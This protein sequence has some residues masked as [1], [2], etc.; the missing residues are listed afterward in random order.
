MTTPAIR[1]ITLGI[2]S[3]HD[4]LRLGQNHY[5]IQQARH[6]HGGD[7]QQRAGP[8]GLMQE[9]ADAALLHAERAGAAGESQGHDSGEGRLDGEVDGEEGVLGG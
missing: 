2:S 4:L 5:Q 3:C 7:G 9:T 1:V 8:V 6:E